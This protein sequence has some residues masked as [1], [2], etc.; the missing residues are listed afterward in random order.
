[1]LA[2]L[3][4]LDSCMMEYIRVDIAPAPA[5][6]R[7]PSEEGSE[8]VIILLELIVLLA[9]LS[10]VIL[11]WTRAILL[12]PESVVMCLFLRIDESGIGIGDFLEDF[13]GA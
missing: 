1:M 5:M 4:W 12:C 10:V 13:L 3:G 6:H 9:G 11:L 7:H 8:Q 2:A